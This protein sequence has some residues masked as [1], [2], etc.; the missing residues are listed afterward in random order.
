M[1]TNGGGGGRQLAGLLR[2]AARS[3]LLLAGSYLYPFS[4][5]RRQRDAATETPPY[6]YKC[7]RT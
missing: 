2:I 5:T 4:Y 7:V 1:D 6:K 3:E